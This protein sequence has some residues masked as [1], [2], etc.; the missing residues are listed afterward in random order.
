MTELETEQLFAEITPDLHAQRLM[1]ELIF[2]MFLTLGNVEKETA[3]QRLDLLA[4]S[5]SS[6]LSKVRIEATDPVL[7]DNAAHALNVS[8]DRMF[9]NIR[10][11]MQKS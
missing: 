7:Q 8:L 1:I 2:Q 9:D 5:L 4:K 11:R 3:V 6:D 10:A